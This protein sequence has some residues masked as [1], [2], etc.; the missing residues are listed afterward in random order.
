MGLFQFAYSNVQKQIPKLY[1][2]DYNHEDETTE[3]Q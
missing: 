1:S 3:L 2:Y